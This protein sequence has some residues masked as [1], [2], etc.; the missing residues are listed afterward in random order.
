MPDKED[1]D[2]DDP[3]NQPPTPTPAPTDPPKEGLTRAQFIAEEKAKQ[4]DKGVE[5]LASKNAELQYDLHKARSAFNS[6][7]HVAMTKADVAALEE[8][9]KH[10]PTPKEAKEASEKMGT[11]LADSKKRAYDEARTNAFAE[12]EDLPDSFKELIPTAEQVLERPGG[13]ELLGKLDFLKEEV[14][15]TAK[16]FGAVKQDEKR[17]T[18]QGVSPGKVKSSQGKGDAAEST[19]AAQSYYKNRY[20]NATKEG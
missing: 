15:R 16:A 7:T 9:R 4:L 1:P 10:Y 8:Y 11:L 13:T 2:P 18:D 5:Y 6:Q 17:D 14:A 3:A 12:Y 19:K 20:P